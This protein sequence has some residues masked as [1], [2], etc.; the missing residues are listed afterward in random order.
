MGLHSYQVTHD[1]K[2]SSASR[3]KPHWELLEKNKPAD[4]L[5]RSAWIKKSE[6]EAR[7][8]KY[9]SNTY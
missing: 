8:Y 2:A 3:L 7:T 5:G 6:S 4:S 1:E 9:L